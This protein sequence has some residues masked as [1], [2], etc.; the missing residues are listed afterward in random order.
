MYGVR[1]ELNGLVS[2]SLPACRQDK[3][4]KPTHNDCQ[5]A[6]MILEH[7]HAKKYFIMPEELY[8]IPC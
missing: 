1:M 2:G 4:S 7:H 8:I 6:L 5:M 3:L